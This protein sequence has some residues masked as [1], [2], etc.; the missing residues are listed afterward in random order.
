LSIQHWPALKS[1]ELSL[2]GVGERENNN[3][4]EHQG[5]YTDDL[6]C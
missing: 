2:A 5:I 4:L 3:I 6:A 1:A